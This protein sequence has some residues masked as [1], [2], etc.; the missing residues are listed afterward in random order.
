M[1]AKHDVPKLGVFDYLLQSIG[2][3]A[4]RA[5]EGSGLGVFQGAFALVLAAWLLPG[6]AAHMASRDNDAHL[7][8]LDARWSADPARTRLGFSQIPP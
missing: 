8:T 7:M 5:T 2:D 3:E 1:P 6:C 4:P